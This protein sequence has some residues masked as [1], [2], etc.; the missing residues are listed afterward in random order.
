MLRCSSSSSSGRGVVRAMSLRLS[1]SS[2]AAGSVQHDT[3]S[4]RFI[5][6]LGGGKGKQ[7]TH[8]LLSD[9]RT[10]LVTIKKLLGLVVSVGR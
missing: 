3:A 6:P 10:V 4:G 5:L 8:T 9:I 1:S 7:T 2:T